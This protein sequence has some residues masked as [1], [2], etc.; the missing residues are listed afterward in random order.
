MPRAVDP[1]EL[2]DAVAEERTYF[3]ILAFEDDVESPFPSFGGPL[4]APRRR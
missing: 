3:D 4:V 1:G 2:V